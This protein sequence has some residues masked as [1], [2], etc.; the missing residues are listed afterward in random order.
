VYCR[1]CAVPFRLLGISARSLRFCLVCELVNVPLLEKW[2][3]EK[4]ADGVCAKVPRLSVLDPLASEI[5]SRIAREISTSSADRRSV[6]NLY[7]RA[8]DN[9]V[10][11]NL[12]ISV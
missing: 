4:N 7:R 1:F 11:R 2:G 12:D 5:A 10:D 8:E 9:F 3:N 6:D